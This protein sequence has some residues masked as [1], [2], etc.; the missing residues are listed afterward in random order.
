[1]ILKQWHDLTSR[2]QHRSYRETDRQWGSTHAYTKQ[3][4]QHQH[5]TWPSRPKKFLCIWRK[6]KV[7]EGKYIFN[8]TMSCNI[9]STTSNKTV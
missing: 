2:T 3:P 5:A 7:R 1:M 9:K 8:F 4:Q 6:S